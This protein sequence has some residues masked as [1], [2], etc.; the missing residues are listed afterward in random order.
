VDSAHFLT[1]ED[2][3]EDKDGDGVVTISQGTGISAPDQNP[4]YDFRLDQ[5]GRRLRAEAS[6]FWG[7][8][9]TLSLNF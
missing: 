7:V 5:P 1:H 2:I 6:L 9:G 3:G 8:S 4:N